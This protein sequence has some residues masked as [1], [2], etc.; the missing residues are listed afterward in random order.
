MFC[1]RTCRAVFVADTIKRLLVSAPKI[2]VT[3]EFALYVAMFMVVFAPPA[4]YNYSASRY[5]F[6]IAIVRYGYLSFFVTRSEQFLCNNVLKHSAKQLF[7][8]CGC[9]IDG[10]STQANC[11]SRCELPPPVVIWPRIPPMLTE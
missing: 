8:K 2:T 4:V 3:P 1:K 10:T 6:T 9:E 11:S 5:A 7:Q